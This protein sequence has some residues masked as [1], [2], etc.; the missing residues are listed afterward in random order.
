MLSYGT[1]SN[2][3]KAKSWPACCGPVLG[4]RSQR[5]TSGLAGIGNNAHAISQYI[6]NNGRFLI[7]PSVQ[8][9]GLAS[10]I[11]ARSARQLAHDW[12][13]HT[14]TPL[15]LETLVD[16][17]RFRGTCYRAANWIYLGQTTGGTRTDRLRQSN[18]KRQA[19]LCISA[20]PPRSAV[21]MPHQSPRSQYPVMRTNTVNKT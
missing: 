12:R 15:I 18:P 9:K 17:G 2:P 6:V 10:A 19:H 14:D 21:A 7:L 13:Q 8:V 4:G 16:A 11:L 3:A 20:A 5:A 1:S